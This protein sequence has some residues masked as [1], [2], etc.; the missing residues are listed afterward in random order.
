M[1]KQKKSILPLCI[2]FGLLALAVTSCKS[3]VAS[4][5][6]VITNGSQNLQKVV[7][8]PTDNVVDRLSLPSTIDGMGNVVKV[9]WAI[10]EGPTEV[11]LVDTLLTMKKDLRE[12]NVKLKATLTYNEKTVDQVI[13]L[14]VPPLTKSKLFNLSMVGT[15]YY[16][17]NEPFL[18]LHIT[19]QNTERTV[20]YKYEYSDL[21]TTNKT[22]RAKCISITDGNETNSVSNSK[23]YL[24]KYK[25]DDFGM[26][27][28][29]GMYD[30]LN[31]LNCVGDFISKDNS[32]SLN[33]LE[34]INSYPTLHDT[35]SSTFDES[36]KTFT[37]ENDPNLKGTYTY[38]MND[39]SSSLTLTKEGTNTSNELYFTPTKLWLFSVEKS[40]QIEPTNN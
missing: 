39:V 37:I 4:A 33:I 38:T 8:V 25:I 10:K 18:T 36:N 35:N 2:T 19:E 16:S 14:T 32:I 5:D 40:W 9:K 11:S 34:S 30:S 17:F 21:D 7:Y 26:I 13:T 20:L 12:Y 6:E 29:K 28:I 23:N 3:P 15:L 24:L 31:G 1:N 27:D 22:F